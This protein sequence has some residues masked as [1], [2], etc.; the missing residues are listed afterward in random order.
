MATE[1]R[2]RAR[3]RMSR[4]AQVSAVSASVLIAVGLTAACSG[5]EPAP[6][7][8]RALVEAIGTEVRVPPHE[9]VQGGGVRAESQRPPQSPSVEARVDGQ[10]LDQ[11][12][13][14]LAAL[15]RTGHE[16]RSVPQDSILR[17]RR[18][19]DNIARNSRRGEQSVAMR[20]IILSALE[21]ESREDFR[22][23]L[24][25]LPVR[26]TDE[27]GFQNGASGTYR[28]Y[29]VNGVT[30][31]RRFIPSVKESGYS[32]AQAEEWDT[33]DGEVRLRGGPHA[34]FGEPARAGSQTCSTTWDGVQYDGE[35]ASQ[36][37]IDDALAVIAAMD[38]EINDDW[39]EAQSTCLIVYGEPQSCVFDQDEEEEEEFAAFG[40]LDGDVSALARRS[41]P[42]ADESFVFRVTP[43]VPRNGATTPT[44]STNCVEQGIAAAVGVIAWVASKV[45][46][47]SALVQGASRSG[48]VA[49]AVGV[50]TVGFSA[51]FGVGTYLACL[52]EE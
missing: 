3:Q 46:A 31:V 13:R 43:C 4:R 33:H 41:G 49:T 38:A 12:A 27:A 29:A 11:Q 9:V 26:L 20:R 37:E 51:G 45:A 16:W 7:E 22:K 48:V 15:V 25:A 47:S 19:L 52:A 8:P 28:S 14:S 10:R 34:E 2:V 44:V 21:A 30:R 18:G 36:A 23:T 40:S 42:S 1:S 24:G 5:E 50:T 39:A 6:Q 35:C 17:W 32:A